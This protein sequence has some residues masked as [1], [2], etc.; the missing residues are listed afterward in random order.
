MC[1]QRGS[2]H[3]RKGW[4]LD[5]HRTAPSKQNCPEWSNQHSLRN[6]WPLK[7]R[8]FAPQLL[9]YKPVVHSLLLHCKSHLKY[10]LK[11]FYTLL[12]ICNGLEVQAASF[13]MSLNGKTCSNVISKSPS[14]YNH[15]GETGRE[16]CHWIFLTFVSV[17]LYP[18]FD[19]PLS[20]LYPL[21][22]SIF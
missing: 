14:Q 8:D 11:Y 13:S 18:S 21:E 1:M 5:P 19:L 4:G 22:L 20:L 3:G 16:N 9:W 10:C 6:I 15:R 17:C 12:C 2:P 7:E